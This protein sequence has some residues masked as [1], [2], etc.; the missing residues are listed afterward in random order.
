MVEASA[1]LTLLVVDDGPVGASLVQAMESA[2]I[3]IEWSR[4]LGELRAIAA[5]C[6]PA[7]VV[8]DLELL[9]TTAD[10]L[11]A[12]ALDTFP[13]ATIVALA[14][15]LTG[16]R[17]ARLLSLGVPSLTK[18]VCPWALAA[19]CLRLLTDRRDATAGAS[20]G[21][22][23]ESIVTSYASARVLS[24]Q[25]QMILRLYL[26]GMNDKGIAD[27]CNCSEATVYEHWRRMAKKAGGTQKGD[28]IADFH[29]F[30][31]GD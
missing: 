18:P 25:Q 16:D 3:Q 23:L 11:L 2:T 19:L 1:G 4:T 29:R 6:E 14:A 30:L 5:R 9:D 31:A 7:I 28:A 20:R 13:S 17:G 26:G 10:A 24:K 27:A 15:D 22:Q 21:S 8:V 12:I